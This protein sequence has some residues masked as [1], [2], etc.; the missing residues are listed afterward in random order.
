MLKNK[1]EL[2]SYFL[3]Y[4]VLIVVM[5]IS[6]R[7]FLGVQD[8]AQL[9]A[10]L[11]NGEPINYM[12]SY[13]LALI[14]S[15]LYS[16]FPSMQWYSIIM[17]F[18][19][20]LIAFILSVYISN[21]NFEN[22][23]TSYIF[24][25]VIFFIGVLLLIYQLLEVDVTSPTLL[26]IALS[27]PLIRKHQIYF[28]AI[29]W[30]A[31][32][33]REQIIFSILPLVV[34]AYLLNVDRSYFNK[35]RVAII[36][37][38]VA[39]ILFNHFSYKL[40]KT[41]NNWMEFTEKRAFYTDFGGIGKQGILSDDEYHLAKGWWIADFDL[42]PKEK[43]EKAA[44]G[45]LDLIKEH[46]KYHH[47]DREIRAVF[48]RHPYFYSLIILS[49]FVSLLYRSWSRFILYSIFLSGFIILLVIKDV[50]R[51]TLPVTLMWWT[52]ILSDIYILR[53]KLKYIVAPLMFFILIWMGY[54]LKNDIPFERIKNFHQREALAKELKDL[55]NKHKNMEF[56]I[57]SGFP[58]SWE[59]LIEAIK[60]DHLFDEK[61]W[62]DYD[63]DFL[64]SGWFS[65]VP[66][67]YKQHHISFNG[68]KRKYAHYHDWLIDPKTAIVGSKGERR[69]ERIFLL[70]NLMRMYDEKFPKKGYKH[71]VKIVD[72]TPHFIIHQVILTKDFIE[73]GNFNISNIKRV[74]QIEDAKFKNV[75][76]KNDKLIAL[77]NDPQLI[78][79][80]NLNSNKK[81]I[82]DLN[83]TTNKETLFQIFYRDTKETNFNETQM[84]KY[85]L[86]KG[87]NHIQL[88]IPAKFLQNGLRI[89]PVSNKGEYKINSFGIYSPIK[90]R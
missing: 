66:M 48:T 44:G 26:L 58:S 15:F 74:L 18:Y 21:I 57:T 9:Y 64:L 51:V 32:F 62:I 6:H 13:P 29:F 47:I 19:I 77:N 65:G 5:I 87:I 36:A 28:W 90:Q 67:L 34:I 85:K 24:K 14:G 12:T 81:F 61:N 37:L 54:Y 49:I 52:L 11:K 80:K 3:L 20:V 60:Q 84:F 79:Q 17:T 7:T 30:I 50:D 25:I 31:S 35:K 88:K 78:F 89:D 55:L 69:H 45:T 59:Y 68:V 76:F 53:D 83:I 2:F 4:F 70:K 23:Y 16:H 63:N 86:K 22:R 33:L 82:L 56:E 73:K 38:L 10:T 40:N 71:L 75:E 41:Y 46:I 1:K 8:E 27:L 42:Y 72:E 39:G 43:I